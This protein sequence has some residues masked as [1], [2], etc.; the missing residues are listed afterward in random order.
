MSG[1][2]GLTKPVVVSNC[3]Q[4][5]T[6]QKGS[7]GNTEHVAENEKSPFSLLSSSANHCG[8]TTFRYRKVLKALFCCPMDQTI[9]QF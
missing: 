4:I 3:C 1:M 8:I 2:K 5:C 9:C 7:F 6:V